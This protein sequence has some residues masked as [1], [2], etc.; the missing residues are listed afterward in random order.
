MSCNH[1]VNSIET[2][3]GGLAGVSEGIEDLNNNEVA[4]EFDN[5]AT[6]AKIKE[7]LEDQSYDL[8]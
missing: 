4:V 3:F 1:C 2:K 7:T 5:A 6:F 8:A